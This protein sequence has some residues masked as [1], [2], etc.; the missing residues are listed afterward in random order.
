MPGGFQHGINSLPHSVFGTDRRFE[1]FTW[2]DIHV[3]GEIDTDAAR[4]VTVSFPD[5]VPHCLTVCYRTSLQR[6]ARQA[7]NKHR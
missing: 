6:A 3:V 7:A 5:A 2:C 1:L 4:G